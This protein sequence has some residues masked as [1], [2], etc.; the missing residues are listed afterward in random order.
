M[1]E[2]TAARAAPPPRSVPMPT[3]RTTARTAPPAPA[4]PSTR[5]TP[6]VPARPSTRTAPPTTTPRTTTPPTARATAPAR[7]PQRPA[8]P[9]P[10]PPRLRVVVAPRH[11]RS[12]AG[13]VVVCVGLLVV[14]LVGLLLLNVS[15]ER[16]TYDLRDQMLR[17]EQLR[18]KKQALD[19]ELRRLSAPQHLD[20]K[21]RELCLVDAPPNNVFLVKGKRVGV[22][23]PAPTPSP[24]SV[25][26]SARSATSD[27]CQGTNATTTGR[28]APG[29]TG[30]ATARR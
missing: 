1:S 28:T 15:L 3:G 23:K 5:T 9:R 7:A 12:R 27:K 29:T 26:P 10:A 24:P 17:A 30:T 20:R 8:Q 22:P 16:G 11:T 14:G 13:L 2:S 21:A 4:R 6:P 19:I 25:T 18:E